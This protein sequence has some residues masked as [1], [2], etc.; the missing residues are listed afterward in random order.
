MMKEERTWRST[1]VTVLACCRVTMKLNSSVLKGIKKDLRNPE[2]ESSGIEDA[3]N[4]V[5]DLQESFGQ[6]P[7]G[8]EK[9]A[10]EDTKGVIAVLTKNVL[11]LIEDNKKWGKERS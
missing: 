3:L 9:A 8:C 10:D 1:K 7:N 6:E 4:N 2:I 5:K 11:P